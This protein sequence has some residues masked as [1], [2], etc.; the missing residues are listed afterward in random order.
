MGQREDPAGS[1][2][3]VGA[4]A[5]F[6][7]LDLAAAWGIADGVAAITLQARQLRISPDGLQA[8]LVDTGHLRASLPALLQLRDAINAVE[9]MARK[10]SEARPN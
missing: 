8:H 4:S 7:Q 9:K 2:Q 3:P 5:P 6:I 10:Q 1:A